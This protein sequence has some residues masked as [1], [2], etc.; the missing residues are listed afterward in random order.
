MRIS[1]RSPRTSRSS[2]RYPGPAWRKIAKWQAYTAAGGI[3]VYWLIDA[4]NCQIEMLDPP[5]GP[6]GYAVMDVLAPG[7][8][9][10]LV[11]DCAEVGQIPV[12]DILP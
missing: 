7:H 1:I 11:I 6:G 5:T 3:P 4:A 9:L 12:A 10:T 8:V 2:S